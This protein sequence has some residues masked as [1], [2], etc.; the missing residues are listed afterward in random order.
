MTQESSGSSRPSKNRLDSFAIARRSS[1]AAIVTD[2]DNRVLECNEAALALL[3]YEKGHPE[4]SANLFDLL[5]ARDEVGNRLGEEPIPFLEMV[6]HG[7]PVNPFTVFIQKR[8][9]DR[10]LVVM[11]VVAVLGGQPDETSLV[12]FLS[13]RLQRR[14]ADELIDRL[15][16]ADGREVAGIALRGSQE[17]PDLTRRQG[18]VL[19][20]LAE[21][22]SHSEIAAELGISINTVHSHV[23]EILR[24]LDVHSQVAAVAR[25]WRDRLI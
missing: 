25:A 22:K 11:S 16:S 2:S 1:T 9:G 5:E 24:R 21:G 10:V 20:L 19:G 23:R 4:A 7:E 12:Y 14:R 6:E 17:Q 18:E 8:S 3:G 15:L 13:P